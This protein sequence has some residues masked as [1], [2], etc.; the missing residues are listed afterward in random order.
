VK[1][2][3]VW[4]I[5]KPAEITSFEAMKATEPP[6]KVCHGGA[7]D[8]FA[9]G[10]LPVLVGSAVHIFHAIHELPK[11]YLATIAWGIETD[12][13]DLQGQVIARGDTENL[14]ENT[15]EQVVIP[16][17]FHE[18]VPP[19]FSNVRVDGERAWKLARAGQVVSLPARRVYLQS[20]QWLSHELPHRS[21][22]RVTV[23]G[24]FYV[25]SLATELGRTLGCRAH[26]QALHREQI[27]P[28]KCPT[29]VQKL[30]LDE[31]TSWLPTCELDD[32]SMSQLKKKEPIDR[33]LTPAQWKLPED[34]PSLT[35]A[36]AVHQ[37][38]LVALL[39]TDP[40]RWA[41]WLST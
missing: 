18:Q 12:N 33:A 39:R 22:L 21:Q 41:A 10:L 32:A 11:T 4:L 14:V 9:T 6:G 34:F 35:F 13:M 17:G 25:R 3:G 26:L 23:R 30:S 37:S 7:L 28:W 5:H 1:T 15:I 16:K 29:E 36:R 20:A 8:P 40:L 19:A 2:Q 31:A 27:G 24:G 38:K